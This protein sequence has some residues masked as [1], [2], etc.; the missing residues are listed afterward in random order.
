MT[1]ATRIACSDAQRRILGA[2]N[3]GSVIRPADR[4]DR[5]GYVLEEAEGGASAARRSI[6]VRHV[7]RLVAIG[8]IRARG[9]V[10]VLTDAGRLAVCGARR[11]REAIHMPADMVLPGLDARA[12]VNI[13]DNPLAWL[14]ARRD[15]AGKPLIDAAQFEAGSRFARDFAQGRL[16]TMATGSWD[17]IGTAGRRK[18][19]GRATA[20]LPD[21]V[22]DA[23]WRYQRARAALGP[24][25]AGLLEDICCLEIGLGAAE[26]RYGWPPRAAKVVL[27]LA[28]SALARHYGLAA[29]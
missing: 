16:N 15:K 12:T 14:R 9:A 22:V 24:E 29:D 7:E 19:G 4:E 11:G 10:F 5:R 2:M 8:A 13:G 20:D 18:S 1:G 6:A 23:R 25:F 21:A 26:K 3:A 17:N 28:L 27:Q